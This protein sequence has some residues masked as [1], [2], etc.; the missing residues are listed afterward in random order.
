MFNHTERTLGKLYRAGF[1]VNVQNE[2]SKEEGK[3]LDAYQFSLLFG[4]S[5]VFQ[6]QYDLFVYRLCHVLYLLQ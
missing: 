2:R 4:G 6:T 1:P 3:W 5:N